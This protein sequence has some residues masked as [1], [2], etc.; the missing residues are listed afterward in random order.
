MDLL[1]QDVAEKR[2]ER[3]AQVWPPHFCFVSNHLVYFALR[4][5]QVWKALDNTFPGH[6]SAYLIDSIR[7]VLSKLGLIT[8]DLA[9][10]AA[11]WWKT[12]NMTLILPDLVWNERS[13][14]TLIRNPNS[15]PLER[16]IHLL[17]KRFYTEVSVWLCDFQ[18]LYDSCMQSL[19]DSLALQCLT[20]L[21]AA[22]RLPAY[23]QG[24]SGC[25]SKCA[26]RLTCLVFRSSA[27]LRG[28]GTIIFT[29]CPTVCK[30]TMWFHIVSRV[31][32]L[33]RC[34]IGR[35]L[36][37]VELHNLCGASK[38]GPIVECIGTSNGTIRCPT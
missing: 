26:C 21:Q 2:K 22:S 33:Q 14:Y 3:L 18:C 5:L 15:F 37:T 30:V 24:Y 34:R 25:R 19:R 23:A 4:P 20:A 10:R 11:A 38:M 32:D 35:P 1:E 8:I 31:F 16:S 36:L 27:N 13:A 17:C 12:Q 6:E 28:S 9:K 29:T 7:A